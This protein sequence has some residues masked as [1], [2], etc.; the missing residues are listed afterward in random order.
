MED[1]MKKHLNSAMIGVGTVL[2]IMTLIEVIDILSNEEFAGTLYSVVLL[3]SFT[4]LL[5]GIL[6]SI[7]EIDKKIKSLN[8]NENI[9]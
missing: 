1:L 2:F 4:L 3:F 6:R 7:S 8:N 9:E 5:C